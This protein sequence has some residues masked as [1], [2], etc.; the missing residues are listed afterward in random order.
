MPGPR[1]LFIVFA[2]RLRGAVVFDVSFPVLRPSAYCVSKE[3]VRHTVAQRFEWSGRGRLRIITRVDE[4]LFG[5][6]SRRRFSDDGF[7]AH[8]DR[9][10]FRHLA[11]R[12]DALQFLL[13][14]AVVPLVD[15]RNFRN[16][17]SLKHGPSIIPKS[18]P[19]RRPYN[20][21]MRGPDRADTF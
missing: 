2:Y 3:T 19:E 11:E 4:L 14:R 5:T 8:H 17:T 10:Q 16:G 20:R 18:I 9:V 12:H 21:A 15:N 7:R 13:L 1:D 6:F